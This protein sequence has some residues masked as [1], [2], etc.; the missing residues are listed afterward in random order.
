MNEVKVYCSKCGQLFDA[1]CEQR[2]YSA[3]GFCLAQGLCYDCQ[4]KTREQWRQNSGLGA[5]FLSCR[6]A[7][8][9]KTEN[10]LVFRKL[11]NYAESASENKLNGKSLVL[12]SDSYGTGKTHFAANIVNHIIDNC[13]S[14]YLGQMRDMTPALFAT[15]TGVMGDIRASYDDREKENEAIIIKRLVGIPMLILDDIGKY[16]VENQN[17]MQRIYFSIIDGRYSNKLPI[18]VTS[19]LSPNKM[20]QH[21]GEACVDRLLEVAEF[22]QLSEHSYRQGAKKK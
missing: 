16:Q 22:I 9:S 18:V 8:S 15:G 19:N 20:V 3:S 14:G 21:I 17:F 6:F 13:A 5:K 7:N 1:E 4:S 11:L 2:H 12:W 10:P